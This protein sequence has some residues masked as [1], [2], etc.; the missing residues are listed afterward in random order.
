MLYQNLIYF[1]SRNIDITDLAQS[2]KHCKKKLQKIF[3]LTNNL[4]LESG[5]VLIHL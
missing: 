5:H 3:I 2:T 4:T 1:S